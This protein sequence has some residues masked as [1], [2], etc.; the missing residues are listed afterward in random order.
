[1]AGVTETLNRVL[2]LQADLKGFYRYAA[3]DAR[4][5]VLARRFRGVKPPQFPSLLEAL[6]NGIACQLNEGSR[7]IPR[8]SSLH[9]T[10]QGSHH[11]QDVASGTSRRAMVTAKPSKT[12]S[13][14]VPKA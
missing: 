4:F 12:S 13:T 11:G 6:V 14:P 10:E 9:A 1:M 8:R 5:S 7:T 3:K 2:G